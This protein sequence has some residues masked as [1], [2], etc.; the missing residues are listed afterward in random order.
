M[1][2]VRATLRLS[3][4]DVLSTNL[5]L[6]CITDILAD[7]GSIQRVKILATDA[8]PN[9]Q[10]VHK[11]NEKS[12]R[13]YLYIKNLDPVSENYI[14]LYENSNEASVAKLAGN[15]FAFIPVDPSLQLMV[16]GTRADQMIEF[17]SFGLD[18]SAVRYS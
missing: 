1:G 15:E 2:T 4:S 14:T 11:P 17:G 7:S 10:V 9:A 3:S 6:T 5:D 16:F 8:G 18:S 13:S 12:D